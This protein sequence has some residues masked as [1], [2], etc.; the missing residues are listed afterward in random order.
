MPLAKSFA[1]LTR[2]LKQF[3]SSTGFPWRLSRI[4]L[5]LCS[6]IVLLVMAFEDKLIYF[7]SKYPDGFWDVENIP[8]RKGS[9]VPKVE[10]CY[11]KTSDGLQLHG[12]FCSPSLKGFDDAAIH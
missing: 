3:W 2:L 4:M 12:W 9:I 7:P 1:M 8:T 5:L 11:F 10:D 6:G